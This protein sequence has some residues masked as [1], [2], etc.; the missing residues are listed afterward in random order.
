VRSY[1]IAWLL[2]FSS[3]DL[4]AKHIR[5]PPILN[6][7]SNLGIGCDAFT[8]FFFEELSSAGYVPS[9]NRITSRAYH[10]SLENACRNTKDHH[11]A[12]IGHHEEI[13]SSHDRNSPTIIDV[14]P[15]TPMTPMTPMSLCRE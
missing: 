5:D 12:T 7:K 10:R 2:S 11:F 15:W 13:L 3:Q 4:R 1:R 6:K 14:P 8:L 9:V